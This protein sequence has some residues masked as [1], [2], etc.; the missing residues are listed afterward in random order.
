[1]ARELIAEKLEDHI[2]KVG[3]EGDRFELAARALVESEEK[4]RTI[5]ENIEDGYYEVDLAGNFVFFNSA[6][7]R[8]TGYPPRELTGMNNREIMDAYNARRVFKVFN[9]VYLTGLAARA[10]DWELI[11]KDVHRRCLYEECRWANMKAPREIERALR[12]HNLS[13][14]WPSKDQVVRLSTSDVVE[15]LAHG[16]RAHLAQYAQVRRSPLDE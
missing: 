1:M 16:A 13:V 15:A 11:K 4:Y 14:T 5:I 6:M 12:I 2:R 7:A 8:M 10:F 3:S 9:K